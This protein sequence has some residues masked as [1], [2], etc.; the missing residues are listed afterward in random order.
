[1]EPSFRFGVKG[2]D[3]L[4]VLSE[5][6]EC[7]LCRRYH[8]A[9]DGIHKSV[10]VLL[11]SA[12]HPTP[13]ILK[14]LAHEY[15]LR[16]ELDG[17]WAVRPLELGSEHSRPVLV[18]DD[19]GG[20]PLQHLLGA[21]MEVG[22]LLRLAVRIAAALGKV[23]DRGLV[24]KDIKPQNIIVNCATGEIRTHRLRHRLSPAPR[25]PGARTAR[26]H[27]RD[28]PIHGPGADGTNEP[29]DRFSERPLRARR[30]PV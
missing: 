17:A 7:V 5:D 23:H 19:P 15:E 1:M 28:A 27:R 22:S 11:S 30:D 13:S 3:G 26:D 21:P 14:R 25:A 8:L 18:L 24:H 10:L 9:V 2:E 12:E 20:G 4:Q 29:L 6:G 16:D